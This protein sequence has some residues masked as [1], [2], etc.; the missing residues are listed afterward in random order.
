MG[1]LARQALYFGRFFSLDE[2]TESIEEVT[3]GQVQH[4]AQEFF[5]PERIALTILGKLDGLALTRDNLTC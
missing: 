1:N 4:L 2:M 5:N 3:A